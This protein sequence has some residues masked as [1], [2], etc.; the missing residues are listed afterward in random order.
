MSTAPGHTLIEIPAELAAE[1]AEHPERFRPNGFVMGTRILVLDGPAAGRVAPTIGL[2]GWEHDRETGGYSKIFVNIASPKRWR[3]P[4]YE[5]REDVPVTAWAIVHPDAERTMF[6]NYHHTAPAKPGDRILILE[7]EQAGRLA[8]VSPPPV[9]L[10]GGGTAITIT[11]K[12][13][14]DRY[15][16]IPPVVLTAYEEYQQILGF[17]GLPVPEGLPAVARLLVKHVGDAAADSGRRLD[18]R[19]VFATIEEAGEFHRKVKRWDLV[20]A[21]EEAADFLITLHIL[22]VVLDIPAPMGVG[23]G[24]PVDPLDVETLA[25]RFV[26]SYRQWQGMARR[27]GTR[28]DAEARL[29]AVTVGLM[30]ACQT[31]HI[32]LAA[33]V[34]AKLEVIFTRGWREPEVARD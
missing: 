6:G 22:Y 15:A 20:G 34:R 16:V 29:D 21:A 1:V 8:T 27:R 5:T 2:G 10:A 14:V 32:D 12:V 26:K 18:D 23:E 24:I 33:A 7:G 4:G 13:D 30:T 3:E 31:L 9:R 17:D 25:T 28:E 11:E 19:Q